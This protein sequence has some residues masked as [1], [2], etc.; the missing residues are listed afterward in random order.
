MKTTPIGLI[1]A[2]LMLWGWQTSSLFFAIILGLIL[3]SSRIIRTR[4]EISIE[5]F[6]WIADLCTVLIIAIAVY[7][8]FNRSTDQLVYILVRYLPLIL[9]PIF[10]AYTYSTSDKIDIRAISL[11]SRRSRHHAKPLYIH[12]EYPFLILTLISASFSHEK[13]RL[14]YP[15]FILIAA[16]GLYTVRNRRYSVLIWL[17]YFLLMAYLGFTAHIGLNKLQFL[18]EQKGIEWFSNM[19]MSDSDPF[20]SIT[21]IGNVGE[22]KASDRIAFRVRPESLQQLPILLKEAAYDMFYK[23]EWFAIRPE[24]SQIE[25]SGKDT[26]SFGVGSEDLRRITILGRFDRGKGLLKVPAGTR[27]ISHLSA[28]KMTRNRFGAIHVEGCPG[29]AEYQAEYDNTGV[30]E[31]PPSDRDLQTPEDS[32]SVLK[33]ISDKLN[34]QKPFPK[35]SLTRLKNFFE[36]DFTYS[37][38]RTRKTSINHF[39]R[40]DRS[41]HCEY[42]ATAGALLLRYAGIPARYAVGFSVYEWNNMEKQ[43]V[44]RTRHAHAWTLVWI[45][46]KWIDADFTPSTWRNSE[47]ENISQWHWLTD[48]W[49]YGIFLFQQWKW[50]KTNRGMYAFWLIVPLVLIIGRRFLLLKKTRKVGKTETENAAIIKDRKYSPFDDIAELLQRQGYVRL[51]GESLKKWINRINID[52]NSSDINYLL[53]IHYRLRFDPQGI[54]PEEYRMLEESSRSWCAEHRQVIS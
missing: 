3:E 40:F 44:V 5:Y 42:F 29:Y 4:F 14:F 51:P 50:E 18:L 19:N 6:R 36:T 37:L 26:W 38:K 54:T 20:R 24:F 25:V 39:L 15:I 21:A 52:K 43:V 11:I 28:E 41:G 1:F 31:D 32:E 33:E 45:N 30:S 34:L 13:N 23:N 17:G 49:D 12:L 16:Y 48:I 7:L 22:L 9:S 10:L 27:L 2:A 8:F 53:N 46:G 35:E 47:S